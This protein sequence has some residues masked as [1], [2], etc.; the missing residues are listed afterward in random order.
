LLTLTLLWTGTTITP[1]A[2]PC[3]PMMPRNPGRGASA[4]KGIP[5]FEGADLLFILRPAGDEYRLIGDA[6]VDGLMLGEAYEGVDPDE[7]DHDI[8]LV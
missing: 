5:V 3:H 8:V 7:V 2:D 6:Y 1:Y 4:A